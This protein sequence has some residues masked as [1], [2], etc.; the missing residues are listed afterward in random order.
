M[1]PPSLSLEGQVA[2]VTGA[3]R[4][5]GRAIALALAQAGADVAVSDIV[6]ED[7][8]LETT[9]Q[10]IRKSG[11]RSLAIKTDV[12]QKTDVDALVE[13]SEKELGPIDVLVN[14]A[15]IGQLV[16]ESGVSGIVGADQPSST[17]RTGWI[18]TS[19]DVWDKVIDTHLKGTNL[20]CQAVAPRMIERQKGNIINISSVMAFTGGSF[21][22]AYSSA[23]AAIIMFTRGLARDLGRYKIRVNA[24]APGYIKTEMTRLVWNNP[25]VLKLWEDRTPLGRLGEPGEI[26]SVALFLASD[27]SSFITG[28]TIVADGGYLLF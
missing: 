25:D 15:G 11:R 5:I 8:E 3:R 22:V 19:E 6:I 28:Q 2:I 24:I 18:P 12:T 4:G 16:G 9:A 23:K 20:C 26:A 27:A 1:P 7:G 14:N 17:V 13:K 10:E 21:V